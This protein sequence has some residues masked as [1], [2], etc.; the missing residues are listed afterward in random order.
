LANIN[1]VVKNDI[2]LKGNLIFEGAT[3]NEF[4]TTLT[5]TDPAADRTITFPD[6]TGTVALTNSPTVPL[7]AQ[8]I[9]IAVGTGL[10]TTGTVNLD[11]STDGY[12]TQAALTGNITYTASNYAAGRS[13]TIRVI[14]GATLR[15]LTFPSGW[16]FLGTKPANIA[17]SKVGV[18][19]ITSFGTTEANCVA[20]W[21]VQA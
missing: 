10:A 14:N 17:S 6:A 1:F 21:S 3:N 9:Q 12:K 5:I 11:F 4:E 20:A 8:N 7:S 19:T 18:L 13:V 16:V 2:E 15:T